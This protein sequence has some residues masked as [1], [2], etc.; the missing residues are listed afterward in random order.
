MVN[1]AHERYKW[2]CRQVEEDE[3]MQHLTQKLRQA[4]PDFAAA[5]AALPP[6]HR[7]SIYE[8]IG[9]LGE[10]AERSKEISCYGP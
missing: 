7:Q 9:I 1:K 3:E 5:M 8:Y 4:Q 6:E 10:I 2:L